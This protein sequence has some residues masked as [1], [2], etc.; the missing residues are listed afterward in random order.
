MLKELIRGL[1]PP[2]L[3][4]LVS[5]IHHGHPEP[6]KVDPTLTPTQELFIEWNA[7]RLKLSTL[8]SR[9]RYL[10]SWHSIPNGHGGSEFRTLYDGT[11]QGIMSVFA[12]DSPAE[13]MNTYRLLAHW[14]FLFFLS[15]GESA[16][17]TDDP[18][19]TSLYG[20]QNVSILDFGCGL[21]R[22]SRALAQYL[23]RSGSVV[24]L[25]LADIP[26]LKHDFLGW[27]CNK[28]GLIRTRLLDCTEDDPIPPIAACHVCFAEE[29]LEH[30]Y[31]P[32]AY[33]T[34]FDEALLPGGFF[35]TNVEDHELEFQHVHPN[36]GDVR[37]FLSANHYLE[38]R[39]NTLFQKER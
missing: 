34:A 21:A 9:R 15:Y 25:Q 2:L 31:N 7:E 10:Q 12:T 3:W 33:M 13:V 19:T 29:F 26:T 18:I 38:I 8:E 11:V 24:Q 37:A 30:V 1:T 27:V 14:T 36:L 20:A 28:E 17:P 4:N 32:I 23:Q 35:V 39:P 22:H 5:R 6:S 16:W